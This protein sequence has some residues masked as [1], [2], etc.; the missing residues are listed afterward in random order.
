[1]PEAYIVAAARTPT[2]R[3]NGSLAKVHPTDLAAFVMR[4]TLTRA[5][6]DPAAVD[7]VIWGVLDPLGGQAHDMARTAWLA[8]G[9]LL[10]EALGLPRE[11]FTPMFAAA[12]AAGW[13][14]HVAEQRESRR[15]L[16]PTSRYVGEDAH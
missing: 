7:D 4:G 11:G 8:A 5:G 15:M 6:V 16:R 10:L 13:V 9:L 2:G 1:M 14:A 12:R 3:R